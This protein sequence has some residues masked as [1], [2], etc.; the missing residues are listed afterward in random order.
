VRLVYEITPFCLTFFSHYLSFLCGLKGMKA[1]EG[2]YLR[3]LTKPRAYEHCSLR[4]TRQE[5]SQ[6]ERYGKSD[7]CILG[8]LRR[9][10]F[11]WISEFTTNRISMSVNNL[12]PKLALNPETSKNE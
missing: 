6:M 8:R 10:F 12:R 2:M 5:N 1:L 4:K 7:R 11:S 3:A 9:A